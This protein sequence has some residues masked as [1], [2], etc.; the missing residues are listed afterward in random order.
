MY[1]LKI[2]RITAISGAL[3]SQLENND[4]M[5]QHEALF[6]EV[7]LNDEFA[8]VSA[9]RKIVFLIGEHE[10]NFQQKIISVTER[11]V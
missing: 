6:E 5:R 11:D 4:E 1:F 9:L 10:K 8:R 7:V 2:S 3:R